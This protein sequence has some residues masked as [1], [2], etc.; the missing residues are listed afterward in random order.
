MGHF[1]NEVDKINDY[2][3]ILSEEAQHEFS[4]YQLLI[5]VLS[6]QGKTDES[7]KILPKDKS[8][9]TA[10]SLQN[11]SDPDATYQNK[12]GKKHKG[13]VGNII[14]TVGENGDSL[15]TGVGK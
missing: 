14:E 12:A 6:E 9:I 3:C 4:E 8:E 2:H 5:R 15:I 11:S 7:G 10:D 1:F 13:Y